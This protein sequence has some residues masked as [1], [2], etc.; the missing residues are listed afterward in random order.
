[1]KSNQLSDAPLTAE[2]HPKV[3]VKITLGF[4]PSGCL[5]TKASYTLHF[6]SEASELDTRSEEI[7][8]PEN[9]IL[10]LVVS[11]PPPLLIATY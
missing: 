1:M 10:S 7:T 9:S 4:L 11:G 5:E 6:S 3:D 2:I 8:I